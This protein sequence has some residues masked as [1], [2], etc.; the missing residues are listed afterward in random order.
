MLCLTGHIHEAAG[1]STLGRTRIVNPGP[2]GRG[3]YTFAVVEGDVE[4]LEIRHVKP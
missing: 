4:Q 2:F 3:G 1:V